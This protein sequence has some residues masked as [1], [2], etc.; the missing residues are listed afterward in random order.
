MTRSGKIHPITCHKR[1][2]ESAYTNTHNHC[3]PSGRHLKDQCSGKLWQNKLVRKKHFCSRTFAKSM[4][5]QNV[6]V[7]WE[8]RQA[9]KIQWNQINHW[10]TREPLSGEALVKQQRDGECVCTSLRHLLCKRAFLCFFQRRNSAPSREHPARRSELSD[11]HERRT[12]ILMDSLC[13]RDAFE[14]F[15]SSLFPF[16]LFSFLSLFVTSIKAPWFPESTIHNI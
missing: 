7:V 8:Q 12:N 6:T 9:D 11:P 13:S 4:K 1:P 10:T 16:P 5:Q 14:F 2:C 15:P 3:L